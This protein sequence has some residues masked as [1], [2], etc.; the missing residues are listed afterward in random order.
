MRKSQLRIWCEQRTAL[1][2][3][4]PGPFLDTL[5]GWGPGG[6]LPMEPSSGQQ[7]VVRLRGTRTVCVQRQGPK[8][9]WRTLKQDLSF[10][11]P[12]S[13]HSSPGRHADAQ[14]LALRVNGNL[15][16]GE[17]ALS[18]HH[19]VLWAGGT[20]EEV[21]CQ[22][23]VSLDLL[24]RLSQHQWRRKEKWSRVH[25]RPQEISYILRLR[26]EEKA[27]E[28]CFLT[29]HTPVTWFCTWDVYCLKSLTNPGAATHP[30]SVYSAPA[31]GEAKRTRRS[32]T[33]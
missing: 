22:T 4:N 5:A 32:W 21:K 29:V 15:L 2:V 11:W 23:P 12:D 16:Q 24:K 27:H 9:L 13:L 33:L 18:C 30:V 6:L 7:P 14:S 3:Q 1:S 31:A 26:L 25:M 28:G 20:E 17:R 8:T 10:I 19:T